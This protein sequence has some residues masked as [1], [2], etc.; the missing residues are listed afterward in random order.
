M[1]KLPKNLR[2]RAT[3]V[4]HV[5][6]PS[7][8]FRA[9]NISPTNIV[10]PASSPE[11]AWIAESTA[12]I[13]DWRSLT[14]SVYLRWAI[15]I[16]ASVRA[17]QRYR[18]T[19]KDQAL[20]TTT[21]RVING[22][23]EQSVIAVWP[24]PEAAENYA[25]TTP[26]ISAY[27]VTDLFG[28]LEDVIFDLYEIFLRHNPLQILSGPEFRK[29][30]FLWHHR[31]DDTAASSAWNAAWAERYGKW[32]RNKAYDGLH[33]VLRAFFNH[34]GLRRPSFYDQ[35]DIED[36]CR[37]LEMIAELRNLI[38]HGAA[39]VSTRLR[40]LSGTRTS[41]TFDFQSDAELD[42]QLHHLQ[43]IECFCDQL[44]TAINIS[45]VEHSMRPK[46]SPTGK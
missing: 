45:L 2:A 28:C 23:P 39:T 33:N 4:P 43:S 40:E 42:V 36:W 38:V 21:L 31:N 30:R 14:I 13:G 5:R 17:E 25:K 26:L 15:T 12:K 8:D 44:L 9:A 41:L 46:S 29:H 18:E 20:Q 34:A 35:T 32:R 6:V 16:N 10:I 1:D 24:A 3:F 27:G 11:E 22:R 37:T 19:P 7:K